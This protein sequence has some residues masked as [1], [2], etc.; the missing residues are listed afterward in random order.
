MA[1]VN[2]D[3]V[4]PIWIPF[5]HSIPSGNQYEYALSMISLN[6]LLSIFVLLVI[7]QLDM[8][9]SSIILEVPSTYSNLAA[10]L[11]A[12]EPGD[13]IHLSSGIFSS[14]NCGIEISKDNITISGSGKKVT[15]LACNSSQHLPLLINA[16]GTVLTNFSLTNVGLPDVGVGLIAATTSRLSI[17]SCILSNGLLQNR[18]TDYSWRTNGGALQ[19]SATDANLMLNFEG[20]S[21]VNNTIS[22]LSS[23]CAGGAIAIIVEAVSGRG[24]GQININ[25]C[26]FAS[27]HVVGFGSSNSLQGAGIY[28]QYMRSAPLEIILN[29][30][31]FIGNTMR[32]DNF[33]ILATGGA[34]SFNNIDF[35][36]TPISTYSVNTSLQVLNC[37]ISYNVLESNVCTSLSADAAN[38]AGF[39]LFGITTATIQESL[40]IGNVVNCTST[41]SS[42]SSGI[43]EGGAIFMQGLADG[44]IL[45][46]QPTLRIS[47]SIFRDNI[48]SCVGTGCL[49]LGGAIQ[50]SVA[51][52]VVIEDVIAENNGALCAGLDCGAQG[53]F[54]MI[55][56][57]PSAGVG[58]VPTLPLIMHNL[59]ASNNIASSIDFPSIYSTPC[60][61]SIASC[62]SPTFGGGVALLS[63]NGALTLNASNWFANN[64]H[65][66]CAYDNCIAFGASFG[67]AEDTI[68]GGPIAGVSSVFLSSEFR[69]GSVS[70]TGN[71]CQALSTTWSTDYVSTIARG[72]LSFY[73]KSC[74]FLGNPSPSGYD[75][76]VSSDCTVFVSDYNCLPNSSQPTFEPS[77]TSQHP[78]SNSHKDIVISVCTIGV[79]FFVVFFAWVIWYCNG[80]QVTKQ[81]PLISRSSDSRQ[82]NDL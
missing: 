22:C 58:S 81:N 26:I 43:A 37:E 41:P 28:L 33:P 8:V 76:S 60:N 29:N 2:W 44:N 65:V 1:L 77:H 38:G 59:N 3:S 42:A 15:I 49:S 35:S 61:P 24:L 23:L 74:L 82:P 19:I 17:L 40:F 34:F 14:A 45:A 21:F 12:A 20:T 4:I 51:A 27:N 7:G 18:P 50:V 79:F 80:T 66:S 11:Q 10:A 75:V 54:A 64:N 57:G 5:H 72:S 36:D 32:N 63:L 30:S 16:Q 56:N 68:T 48:A 6:V 71:N 62:S 13:T 39:S 47:H 9:T 53:G 69:C 70:C 55:Q 67:S 73:G 46:R 52:T 78:N 25:G 31:K